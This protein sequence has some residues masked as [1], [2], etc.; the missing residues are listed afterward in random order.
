[1][2]LEWA[3]D[4]AGGFLGIG[5]LH[6]EPVNEEIITIDVDDERPWRQR[7]GIGEREPT[8]WSPELGFDSND[9][10]L[11]AD[12]PRID[13]THHVDVRAHKLDQ[14]NSRMKNKM[15]EARGEKRMPCQMPGR[16]VNM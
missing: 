8:H 9:P 13:V 11:Y 5:C 14:E 1:M 3:S 6:V 4:S 16:R 12:P 15:I 2:L 10:R 7:N